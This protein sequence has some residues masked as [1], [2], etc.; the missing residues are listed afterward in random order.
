MTKKKIV[1]WDGDEKNRPK[2]L[3]SLKKGQRRVVDDRLLKHPVFHDDTKKK[4]VFLDLNTKK[5]VEMGDD[6]DSVLLGKSL[7]RGFSDDSDYDD[8]IAPYGLTYGATTFTMYPVS[9]SL[10]LTAT[11]S[12]T[13]DTW[14]VDTSPTL[15]LL[16]SPASGSISGLMASPNVAGHSIT[17]TATNDVGTD[18]VTLSFTPASP[19]HTL[20]YGGTLFAAHTVSPTLDMTPSV[21]G[22]VSLWS[23]APSPFDNLIFS[24]ATGRISGL[25]SSPGA[26]QQ[27]VVVSAINDDGTTTASLTFSPQSP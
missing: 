25:V 9:P 2:H 18:T 27:T 11:I 1:V 13:V 12:G 8:T 23:V 17:V 16:F 4:A 5:V 20:S 14:S 3:R 19:P 15:N 24:P 6:V 7:Y 10:D 21:V 26:A 22:T